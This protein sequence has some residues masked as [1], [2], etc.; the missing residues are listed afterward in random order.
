MNADAGRVLLAHTGDE[1][2]AEELRT[3]AYVQYLRRSKAGP[4]AVEDEWS[5]MVSDGCGRTT[6]V[7][8]TVRAVEE[9]RQIGPKTEI[10]YERANG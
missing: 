7:T 8:L 10:E 4:I 9:G 1:T 2:V 5:E 3:T 6:R